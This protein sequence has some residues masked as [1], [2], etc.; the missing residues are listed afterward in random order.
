M[1]YVQSFKTALKSL[2]ILKY[3]KILS[4]RK[5]PWYMYGNVEIDMG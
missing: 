2:Y 3:L 5:I 4:Q 1:G